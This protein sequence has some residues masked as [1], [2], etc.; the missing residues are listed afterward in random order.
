MV[1]DGVFWCVCAAAAVAAAADFAP[2][3]TQSAAAA[4]AVSRKRLELEPFGRMREC[5]LRFKII[6]RLSCE[7]AYLY[8]YL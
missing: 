5:N 4:T 6:I 1:C 2:P 8:L 7:P 3:H